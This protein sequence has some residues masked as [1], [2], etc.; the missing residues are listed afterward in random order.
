VGRGGAIIMLDDIMLPRIMLSHEILEPNDGD[1]AT[2]PVA[3]GRRR[4]GK[5]RLLLEWCRRNG[6]LYASLGDSPGV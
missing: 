4:I 1:A 5:T 2:G 3:G 6:G